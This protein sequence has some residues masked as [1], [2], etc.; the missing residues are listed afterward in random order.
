MA[1]QLIEKDGGIN[2]NNFNGY[3]LLE[4]L[5]NCLNLADIYFAYEPVYKYVVSLNKHKY[6]FPKEWHFGG[7]G[8]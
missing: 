6:I 2:G 7:K 3:S 5:E 1:E 8:I 4:S